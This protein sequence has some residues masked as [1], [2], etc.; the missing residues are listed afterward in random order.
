VRLGF[1]ASQWDAG[2]AIYR[3]WRDLS[4]RD[5]R[6]AGTLGFD[7]Q[8]WTLLAA[9]AVELTST[10]IPP[11]PP[12]FVIHAGLV[13]PL[14][15]DAQEALLYFTQSIHMEKWWPTLVQNHIG[16][17][18]ILI[19]APEDWVKIRIP[20]SDGMCLFSSMR[21][22]LLDAASVPPPPPPIHSC[23]AMPT[24]ASAPPLRVAEPIDLWSEALDFEREDPPGALERSWDQLSHEERAAALA[25]GY[26]AREWGEQGTHCSPCIIAQ[27]VQRGY[28]SPLWPL[29]RVCLTQRI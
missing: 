26:V 1:T 7:E 12:G 20:A 2:V 4:P 19:M 6:D 13:K 18:Q 21:S 11:P 14:D 28:P 3:G 9:A 17:Q 24:A 15:A 27:A 16:C 29:D 23:T 22:S 5:Q 8:M 10:S 25:L